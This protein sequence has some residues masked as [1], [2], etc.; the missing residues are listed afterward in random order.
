MLQI[1][2]FEKDDIVDGKK[3][4]TT[5]GARKVLKTAIKENI[6]GT[7]SG[8]GFFSIKRTAFVRRLVEAFLILMRFATG[9]CSFE[10]NAVYQRSQRCWGRESQHHQNSAGVFGIA[11]G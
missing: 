9:Q 1:L 2:E 4:C 6:S 5:S 11:M 8:A 3:S 10:L 7:L